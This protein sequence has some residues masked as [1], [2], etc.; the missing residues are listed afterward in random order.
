MAKDE[1]KPPQLSTQEAILCAAQGRLARLGA[2]GIRLQDIARDAG[3]SHPTILHHFGSRDGLI[4]ALVKHIGQ[5]SIAELMRRAPQITQ[6][7]PNDIS[8]VGLTFEV[9]AD[10]GFGALIGW[11]YRQRPADI[12]PM[13]QTMFNTAFDSIIS[14]KTELEGQAPDEVWQRELAYAM[15]VALMAAA[16]ETLIGKPIPMGPGTQDDYRSWLSGLL[17]THLGI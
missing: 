16:G 11:A 1:P 5:I 4:V 8:K 13:I 6:R 10:K 14:Q 7:V 3:V 9:L 17:G 12:A 15:R 2:D